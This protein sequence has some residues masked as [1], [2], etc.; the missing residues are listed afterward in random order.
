MKSLIRQTFNIVIDALSKYL[1]PPPENRAAYASAGSTL[2]A[3]LEVWGRDGL[4]DPESSTVRLLS[5]SR[6]N[7]PYRFHHQLLC[8]FMEER[9]PQVV[10]CGPPLVS[11]YLGLLPEQLGNTYWH[12]VLSVVASFTTGEALNWLD[13][14]NDTNAPRYLQ[15]SQDFEEFV[16]KTITT[17]LEDGTTH[18]KQALSL[19][20][21]SGLCP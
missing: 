14:F 5:T 7:H 9:L 19:L 6:S 21:R 1:D 10:R 4:E 11:A 16:G 3:L 13:M 15:P 20:E 2:K 17:V 8:T 18:L 12:R